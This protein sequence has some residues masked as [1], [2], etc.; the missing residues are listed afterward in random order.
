[1]AGNRKL[2]VKLLNQ[3]VQQQGSAPAD[4]AGALAGGDQAL[5][6]RLAHT[7]KG[8]AGNIGAKSVQA[9]AGVL[10]KLI[11]EQAST[12]EVEAARKEVGATLDPLVDRLRAALGSAPSQDQ[13]TT[14]PV[15]SVDPQ[16]VREAVARLTGLLSEYDPAA[17]EFVEANAAILRGLFD[18][19]SWAEFEKLVQG[20]SFDE[21]KNRLDQ[22]LKNS[23][24]A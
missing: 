24:S 10:E 6:E 20:Y 8:V 23:P 18:D 22:V 19:G 21:A 1:V 4:I 12:G 11:R 15:A 7:L 3:F 13:T 17:A 5:A 2:Y 16:E 9:R 14:R